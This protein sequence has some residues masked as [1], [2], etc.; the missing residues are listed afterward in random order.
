MPDYLEIVLSE[1]SVCDLCVH[2][3]AR[4]T[5]GNDFLAYDYCTYNKFITIIMI[6]MY[7]Y[8]DSVFILE[9]HSY[10]FC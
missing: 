2:L 6:I 8:T 3:Q 1:K 5:G 10:Q 7:V 9:L 4:D